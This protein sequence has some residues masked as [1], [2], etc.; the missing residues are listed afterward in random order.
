MILNLIISV[1]QF[2]ENSDLFFINKLKDTDKIFINNLLLINAHFF[3]NIALSVIS[4]NIAA[5]LFNE[6]CMLHF[7]LKIFI[8]IHFESIC[9]ISIQSDLVALLRKTSLIIWNEISAQYYHCFKVIDRTLKDLWNNTHWFDKITI[10]FVNIDS[11][12]FIYIF[13]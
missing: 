1:I 6:N 10:M 11:F 2:N 8:E 5:I 12:T 9:S 3:E 7:R 4:F 13:H